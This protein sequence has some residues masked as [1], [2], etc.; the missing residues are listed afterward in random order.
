MKRREE[1]SEEKRRRVKRVREATLSA[2]NSYRDGVACV[3]SQTKS[4]KFKATACT[5]TLTSCGLRLLPLRTAH[6]SISTKLLIAASNDEAMAG[7]TM[8]VDVRPAL[9]LALTAADAITIDNA[10][11]QQTTQTQRVKCQ[12]KPRHRQSE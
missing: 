4:K 10:R 2:C 9:P 1:K 11:T 3:G 5:C 12:L 7:H 6:P 8:A